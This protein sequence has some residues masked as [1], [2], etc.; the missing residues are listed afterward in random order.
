MTALANSSVPTK[1]LSIYFVC[2]FLS[3]KVVL[4]GLSD[5]L[6]FI[7]PINIVYYVLL[8]CLYEYLKL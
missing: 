4:S 8:Q 6:P 1:V 7:F 3:G 2:H 5:L